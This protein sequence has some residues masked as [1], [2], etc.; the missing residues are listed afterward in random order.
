MQNMNTDDAQ[1][2]AL[3]REA[4]RREHTLIDLEDSD[5]P[6]ISKW[7]G[8]KAPVFSKGWE[9][10]ETE[11]QAYQDPVD[12]DDMEDADEE[13]IE[14][15]KRYKADF[16]RSLQCDEKYDQAVLAGP[17]LNDYF[18]HFDLTEFQVIAMCRTYANYLAQKARTTAKPK[19]VKAG[20]LAV[21]KLKI[22]K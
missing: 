12:M 15:D 4:L 6:K 5:E 11:F 1:L 10:D 22:K 14:N 13:I 21:K 7:T 2:K 20:A 9:D 17:D 3:G 16:K 8:G 19:E 18:S